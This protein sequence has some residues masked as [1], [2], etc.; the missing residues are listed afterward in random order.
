MSYFLD[1]FASSRRHL[2]G[3]KHHGVSAVVR[4]TAFRLS[5]RRFDFKDH[6]FFRTGIFLIIF[7][8]HSENKRME[9]KLSVK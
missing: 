6:Y 8:A 4:T 3:L 9:K 7:T 1:K 2:K 5:G